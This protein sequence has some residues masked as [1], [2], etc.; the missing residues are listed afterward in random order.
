MSNVWILFWSSPIRYLTKLPVTSVLEDALKVLMWWVLL[1]AGKFSLF[2]VSAEWDTERISSIYMNTHIISSGWYTWIHSYT[3]MFHLHSGTN[4]KYLC[5]DEKQIAMHYQQP[6]MCM[7]IITCI[8]SYIVT[9]CMAYLVMT[10]SY[11]TMGTH[12]NKLTCGN[13]GARR[14]LAPL[15]T[16]N[17]GAAVALVFP[18]TGEQFS[19]ELPRG[20][21]SLA[22][23]LASPDIVW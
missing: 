7:D 3:H 17:T 2:R 9:Y 20:Y 5:S 1:C 13:M 11:S 18:F 8:Y 23:L 12:S 19:C 21:W 22:S 10:S 15:T 6:Y 14:F 4:T 16:T